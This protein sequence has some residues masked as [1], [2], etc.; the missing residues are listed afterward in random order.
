M[1]QLAGGDGAGVVPSLDDQ[2]VQLADGRTLGWAE[3]GHPEGDAVVF[4]H[5]TPGSRLDAFTLH[6]AALERRLRIVAPDR[7]GMGR[8]T[9]V[10]DRRVMHHAA[11]VASLLD[12][13]RIDRFSVIAYSGGSPY[14]L[15]C[16]VRLGHRVD[17]AVVVSGCSP[18]DRPAALADTG[19]IDRVLTVLSRRAPR[20]AGLTLRS[21][22]LGARAAPRV[23]LRLW[24]AD[25]SASDRV[26]FRA[27]VADRTVNP[28]GSFFESLRSGARGAVVDYRLLSEPWGFLPEQVEHPVTFW[29]GDADPIVPL[30]HAHDLVARMPRS[31]LRVVEG[32]GH[33]LVRSAAGEILD[34]LAP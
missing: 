19:F 5:G 30:H 4:L 2:T 29:H 18:P 11:D 25:L 27:M 15:A 16:A 7:P 23:G 33:F 17:H 12:Q 22:A 3:Y 10:P 21:M 9:F 31:R 13:L 28:L 32:A 26:A 1:G 34:P 8:S 6:D 24:E 14:G 20:L